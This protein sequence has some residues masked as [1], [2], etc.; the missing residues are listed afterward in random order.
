MDLFILK[1]LFKTEEN[2]M[3]RPQITWHLNLSSSAKWYFH[4]SYKR[5][6]FTLMK[7]T[8]ANNCHASWEISASN[9]DMLGLLL[10]FSRNM[11]TL[12]KFCV[13][14]TSLALLN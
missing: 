3:K 5:Y 12:S 14:N 6:G 4:K 2:I 8:T 1:R 13:D 7:D 11:E 9:S 10:L